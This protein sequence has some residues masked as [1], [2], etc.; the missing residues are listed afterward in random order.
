MTICISS[1]LNE[2]HL[3]VECFVYL[4]LQAIVFQW[5]GNWGTYFYSECPNWP[6]RVTFLLPVF[7]VSLFSF[8]SFHKTDCSRNS[9]EPFHTQE[10]RM[11]FQ[12]VKTM[13]SNLK[14]FLIENARLYILSLVI[15]TSWQ[16]KRWPLTGFVNSLPLFW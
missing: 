1:L 9:W 8:C 13:I 3:A 12:A 15:P 7:S 16:K 14:K 11:P 4:P 5:N 6:K 10:V 2:L